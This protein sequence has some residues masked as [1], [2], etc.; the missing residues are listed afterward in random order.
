MGDLTAV[1]GLADLSFTILVLGGVF[2]YRIWGLGDLIKAKTEELE[3][4]NS[5]LRLESKIA[6][7]DVAKN[8]G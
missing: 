8:E 7:G 2:L 5:R 3:L 4:R 1:S 6:D